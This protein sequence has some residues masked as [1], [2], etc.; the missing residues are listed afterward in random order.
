[1]RAPDSACVALPNGWVE[2]ETRIGIMD[3][4]LSGKR[5]LV[6]GSG[7]G[8]GEVM[9]Q[10][11]PG[12]CVTVVAHGRDGG[13]GQGAQAWL[14]T[15]QLNSIPASSMYWRHLTNSRPATDVPVG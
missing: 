4:R 14:D 10:F 8:S 7:A 3:L 5:A 9:A 2:F 6:T 13:L 11:L 1:F 12:A 15:Y